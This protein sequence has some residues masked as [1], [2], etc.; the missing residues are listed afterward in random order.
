MSRASSQA[1]SC[2]SRTPK[3]EAGA[4]EGY[5][6]KVPPNRYLL[7]GDFNVNSANKLTVRYVQLDSESPQL[8]SN[9][10]SL[11][12]GNRRTSTFGLNFQNSN[13][14]ILENI[15]SI[16]GEWN[17]IIGNSM[18]N[19]LIVGYTYQDESRASRGSSA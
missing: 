6:F 15:R 10:S 8:A 13:Y 4:Y 1:A 12:F 3:A 9:S 11:G 2:G 7:K 14:Q 17:S 16:V 18:A 5:D 19:S